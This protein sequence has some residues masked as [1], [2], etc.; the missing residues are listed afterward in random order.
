MRARSRARPYKT[1]FLRANAR[2]KSGIA[3]YRISTRGLNIAVY[4]IDGNVNLISHGCSY[5]NKPS[6]VPRCSARPAL[7]EGLQINAAWPFR[8]INASLI[9]FNFDAQLAKLPRSARSR[10]FLCLRFPLVL[11]FS[12]SPYIFHAL[13][14]SGVA[15]ARAIC[16]RDVAK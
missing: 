10:L 12:L 8:E 9:R 7:R 4:F 13:C 2:R 11:Y 1:I 5:E 16:I 15:R 3:E 6:T 14:G